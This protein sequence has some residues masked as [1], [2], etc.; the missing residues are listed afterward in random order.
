MS[1]AAARRRRQTD[2]LQNAERDTE[3]TRDAAPHGTDR[4]TI[5]M[6]R[7]RGRGVTARSVLN[8]A[9]W[10]RRDGRAA[11]RASGRLRLANPANRVDL[12]TFLVV[13]QSR[14]ESPER[15]QPRTR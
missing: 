4:Q 8:L 14:A 3:R 11:I 6:P 9:G 2:K 13:R 7:R 1:G 15:H 10:R 5:I 12:R